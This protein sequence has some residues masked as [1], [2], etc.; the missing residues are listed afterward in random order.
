MR[1]V[2]KN[3]LEK[4]VFFNFFIKLFYYNNYVYLFNFINILSI[5]LFYFLTFQFF[6]SQ[7]STSFFRL[8]LALNEHFLKKEVGLFF[9]ENVNLYESNPEE[10]P[11]ILSAEKKLFIKF[12]DIQVLK[13]KYSKEYFLQ[14]SIGVSEKSELLVLPFKVDIFST[15]YSLFLYNYTYNYM[16]L[17]LVSNKYRNFILYKNYFFFFCLKQLRLKFV[18]VTCRHLYIFI[19]SFFKKRLKCMFT[20]VSF[21]SFFFFKKFVFDKK[22]K[23]LLQKNVNAVKFSKNLRNYFLLRR[24]KQ[25]F[26]HK[27]FSIFSQQFFYNFLPFG[28]KFNST[29]SISKKM[30]SSLLFLPDKFLFLNYSGFF[31]KEKKYN[32]IIPLFNIKLNLRFRQKKSLPLKNT[33]IFLWYLLNFFESKLQKPIFLKLIYS[34]KAIFKK[35]I[36]LYCIRVFRKL[37]RYNYRFKRNFFLGEIIRV[38]V[39]SLMSRDSTLLINYVTWVLMQIPYKDVKGFLYFLKVILKRHLLPNFKNFFLI[40]GF[41]FDIRGK[42]GVTGD[43]KKRHT[44]ISWGQSSFSEKNLKLSLKQGLVYTRTGVMGVTVIIVF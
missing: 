18:S 24:Q 42:V 30:L 25:V 40:K 12:L 8:V 14:K 22:K 9:K 2:K 35:S 23:E 32:N 21:R 3:S 33:N 10:D 36:Y 19:V 34:R 4:R 41:V 26:L 5:K 17:Q 13:K 37:K 31:I 44:L 15:N 39:V 28:L 16:L 27:Y 1:G 29:N 7:L 6:F 38:I 11:E 43:A 20:D